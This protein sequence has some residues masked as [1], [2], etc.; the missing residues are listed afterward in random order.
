M[1]TEITIDIFKNFLLMFYYVFLFLFWFTIYNLTPEFSY[2]KDNLVNSLVNGAIKL[3][4]YIWF[5]ALFYIF[6]LSVLLISS[7][8]AFLETKISIINTLIMFSSITLGF[9]FA[10]YLLKGFNT[11]SGTERFIKDIFYEIKT[12]GKK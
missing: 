6:A 4:C 12:G 7:A 9:S 2:N 10:L 1:V 11:F 3:N 8:T 5:I